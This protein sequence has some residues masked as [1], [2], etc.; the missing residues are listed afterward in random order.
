MRGAFMTKPTS[1]PYKELQCEILKRIF[2]GNNLLERRPHSASV[3][4]DLEEDKTTA[5]QLIAGSNGLQYQLYP[6]WDHLA[7]LVPCSYAR[8]RLRYALCQPLFFVDMNDHIAAIATQP[9]RF[10]DC[11]LEQRLDLL[12]SHGLFLNAAPSTYASIDDPGNRRFII[13]AATKIEVQWLPE[14]NEID[15]PFAVSSSEMPSFHDF[16]DQF[17]SSNAELA[18]AMEVF[19]FYRDRARRWAPPEHI[20]SQRHFETYLYNVPL[21]EAQHDLTGAIWAAFTSWGREQV[22]KIRAFDRECGS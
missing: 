14:Q 16:L 18:A 6:H 15:G 3:A 2:R 11:R 20:V 10:E 21:S 5:A 9:H 8:E 22:T 12:R 1:Y 7:P 19:R 17:N 13:C 4:R